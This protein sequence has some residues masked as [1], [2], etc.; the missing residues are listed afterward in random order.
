MPILIAIAATGT[1]IRIALAVAFYPWVGDPVYSYAYRATL[2]ARGDWAGVFL[3]WHPPGYPLVLALVTWLDRGWVSPYVAGVAVNLAA[4]LG[5]LWILDRL[6]VRRGCWPQTRLV[7]ASFV[8][9]YQGLCELQSVPLTE[10]LYL[11]ILAAVVLI[12]D[13]DV[14]GSGG[15]FAAGVLL[16]LASTLRFEGVV[17]TAGLAALLGLRALRGADRAGRRRELLGVLA[18]VAGWAVAAGWLFS[19]WRYVQACQVVQKV[20]FT[21]PPA[22]SWA[23]F[24]SRAVRTAYFACTDWLPHTLLLPYWS[25]AVIGLA[26]GLKDRG[27]RRQDVLWLALIVPNLLLVAWT[28]MHKRTGS[29]LLPASALWFGVGFQALCSGWAVEGQRRLN[30]VTAAVIV[31]NFVQLLRVPFQMRDDGVVRDPASFVEAQLLRRAGAEPG[32]IWA[33]NCEPEVY[34]FLEWPIRFPFWQA[35]R[36]YFP[37]YGDH[38]GDPA[39]FVESLRAAGFKYL[40]FR[41]SPGPAPSDG[42]AEPQPYSNLPWRSDLSRLI[43]EPGRYRIRL[44]GRAPCDRGRSLAYAF[45]IAP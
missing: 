41:S 42:A 2:I 3:M 14:L 32:R 9:F 21:F 6:A 30:A 1:L 36:A 8:A 19:H 38:R 16:G 29:F 45:E 18:F 24:P 34:S 20:N 40:A 26:A 7:I 15:G 5:L 25:V 11:L 17:P 37:L 33:F 22:G 31:L 10:P 27:Q 12:A 23:G 44:L 28:I 39:G 4:W 43:G 13:R 35:E